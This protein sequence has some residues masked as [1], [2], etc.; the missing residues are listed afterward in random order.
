MG[1]TFEG[2]CHATTTILL[3]PHDLGVKFHRISVGQRHHENASGAHLVAV[4]RVQEQPCAR[5]VV[6][7]AINDEI[8]GEVQGSEFH[9]EARGT[10]GVKHLATLVAA[11][12]QGKNFAFGDLYAGFFAGAAGALSAGF[13]AGLS[14]LALS[15]VLSAVLS[16]GL[17]ALGLSLFSAL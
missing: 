9:I 11:M 3:N 12:I 17:S 10:S 7:Y 5:Q 1:C 4:G 16:A 2:Q 14:V 6:H 13:S 8:V 15:L